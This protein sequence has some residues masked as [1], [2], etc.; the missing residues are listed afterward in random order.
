MLR[1]F[2][3]FFL[4]IQ[5]LASTAHELESHRYRV[6]VQG[7]LR[8]LFR[9]YSWSWGCRGGSSGR[10]VPAAFSQCGFSMGRCSFPG[11][12]RGILGRGGLET[13][14]PGLPLLCACDLGVDHSNARSSVSQT[15][16]CQS[17]VS[18][19]MKARDHRK[20]F[21]IKPV[22]PKGNQP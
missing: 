14:G 17:G 9:G 12:R 6:R 7:L 16:L 20:I 8:R 11:V 21:V 10:A 19:E 1:V 3:S 5:L 2:F 15:C 13:P 22:H 18:R 4:C